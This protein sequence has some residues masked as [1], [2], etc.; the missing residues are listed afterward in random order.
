[1]VRCGTTGADDTFFLGG[2]GGGGEKNNEMQR[3]V[4]QASPA[5]GLLWVHT[6]QKQILVHR[7]ET[8]LHQN[9]AVQ[10]GRQLGSVAESSVGTETPHACVGHVRR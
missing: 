4:G 3:Q 5:G 10:L 2:G 9:F 8:A 7:Q 1:M 6:V